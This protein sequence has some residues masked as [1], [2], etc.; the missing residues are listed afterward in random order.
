ME[1]GTGTTQCLLL[2]RCEGEAE[3]GDDTVIRTNS[4]NVN[5]YKRSGPTAEVWRRLR[6]PATAETIDVDTLT[7]MLVSAFANDTWQ[8]LAAP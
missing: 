2:R 7:T 3:A 5:W 8:E 4:L 1:Y 6:D